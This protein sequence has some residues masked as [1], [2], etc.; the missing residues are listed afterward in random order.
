LEFPGEAGPLDGAFED[1]G[2]PNTFYLVNEGSPDSKGV[3]LINAL[4][5]PLK[6]NDIGSRIA[7]GEGQGTGADVANQ[8]YPTY[9]IYFNG[10]M[11]DQRPQAGDPIQ[12]F[13]TNPFYITTPFGP[14]PFRLP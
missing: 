8:V 7:E 10:V 13:N 11:K 4:A 1:T 14:A 2:N 9:N 5:S 3:M 12:N 6:W